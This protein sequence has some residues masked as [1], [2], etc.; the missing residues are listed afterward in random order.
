MSTL[1]RQYSVLKWIL[2]VLAVLIFL[3]MLSSPS[4]IV[5]IKR[6]TESEMFV[7]GDLLTQGKPALQVRNVQP[8]K[9]HIYYLKTHKTASTT[10]YSILAEYCRAHELV[11]L[12]PVGVH[13]NQRPPFHPS[14]LMLHHKVSKY[15]MVFNHHI[16]TEEI[17]RYLHNDTFTFTTIRDPFKHFISS[18]S[19]FSKFN[20]TYLTEIKSKNKLDALLEN[21]EQYETKGYSSYTN[22]RQSLD[23]GFDIKHKF[24]DSTYIKEFISLTE[25]RFQLVLITDY[26]YESL[27]LLKRALNWQTGDILFYK[28]QENKDSSLLLNSATDKQ[29]KQHE[30][31]STADIQ[32]YKYFLQIF[33]F[34]ISKERDIEGEVAE[35]QTVLSRV[36]TFC[37]RD[38]PSNSQ[39]MLETGRWSDRIDLQHSKCKWLKL[40]EVQFTKYLQNVQ[41]SLFES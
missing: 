20:L 24:N 7:E 30:L 1:F 39:F 17:L 16:Y 27:I 34:K 21:P 5:F 29:R 10:I 22:N 12:L 19:Y 35:F 25:K 23:L 13:I 31:F 41:R 38:L 4:S 6:F 28:K 9:Q 37:D 26:F 40:D 32:V 8:P 18:F 33:K 11:P 14:Q 2:T 3:L 15:D 36:H